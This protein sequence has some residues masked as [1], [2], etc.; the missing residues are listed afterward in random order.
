[1]RGTLDAMRR[2]IAH[3]SVASTR[4]G[5]VGARARSTAREGADSEDPRVVLGVAPNASKEELK[6]AYRREALRW[7]P[8]RAAES[9]K[10]THEARFKK[11]SAA[12]ARLSAPGGMASNAGYGG[13]GGGGTA[14]E[15]FA[16]RARAASARGG[17]SGSGTGYR[18]EYRR[19]FSREDA[20]R[21]F[22]EI[23]GSDSS[24]FLREV[25]RAMR[26]AAT[27]GGGFP[28]RGFGAS[29]FGPGGFAF[30]GQMSAY[31]LNDLFKTIFSEQAFGERRGGG[32][33]SETSYVNARGET[34]IRRVT[35]FRGPNGVVSESV[36]ERVVGR[37]SAGSTPGFDP[38]RYER[39]SSARSPPP[40]GSVVGV[41][42]LVELAVG[43]ARV[44][45]VA[46]V[47]FIATF[48]A[49][50]LQTAIRFLLRRLFGG[51][52]F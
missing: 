37:G 33:V 43:A 16:R 50:L 5:L 1:M 8:D 30:R 4:G 48:G 31:D 36:T 46:F 27:R 22:R 34:V 12:Y 47:R 11:I 28:P 18:Y 23:F 26:E 13:G 35:R 6:R 25:E 10:A 14:A 9:E 15:D 29:G 7:H 32:E 19:D 39:A 3:R 49:R 38:F 20:E 21:V 44:L 42:P 24:S 52:R 41:N 45:R 51:G 17:E 40:P 2:T